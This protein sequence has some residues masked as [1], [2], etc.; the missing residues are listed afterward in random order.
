MGELME[1]PE[2]LIQL[3]TSYV[4][5]GEHTLSK[6]SPCIAHDD[7]ELRTETIRRGFTT[8]R[9]TGGASKVL[10]D[11]VEEGLLV[12]PRLFQW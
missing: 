4:L 5:R 2:E 8:V 9:D 7:W 1:T 12:G 6:I 3:R 10:A 11:A